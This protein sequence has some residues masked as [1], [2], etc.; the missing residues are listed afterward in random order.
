MRRW[1]FVG[2]LFVVLYASSFLFNVYA[3]L[4]GEG[5]AMDMGIALAA[6]AFVLTLMTLSYR[7]SVIRRLYGCIISIENVFSIVFLFN[8]FT[9]DRTTLTMVY[10][11]AWYAFLLVGGIR[12]AV[13][14]GRTGGHAP[15]SDEAEEAEKTTAP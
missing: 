7:Y 5:D 15:Q 8:G 13:L 12:M 11:C 4:W 9:G 6:L 10:E 14:P 3:L 2:E 1:W